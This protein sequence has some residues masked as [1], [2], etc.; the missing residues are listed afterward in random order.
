MTVETPRTRRRTRPPT[1]SVFVVDDHPAVR[2]R[3][4]ALLSD[5]P[6][7]RAAGSA[8]NA[9][10][11]L[12]DVARLTPRV[13]VIDSQ[14]GGES[15]LWLADQVTQLPVPPRTLIYSAF[16]DRRLAMAALVAGAHGIV[17][18]TNLDGESCN[19]I[20]VIARGRLALPLLSRTEIDLLASRLGEEDRPVPRMLAHGLRPEE[21]ARALRLDSGR[22]RAARTRIVSELTRAVSPTSAGRL[23][24]L[25]WNRASR[26]HWTRPGEP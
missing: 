11:A 10:A 5:K 7:L 15:G 24:Q 16:A 23:A 20:R 8:T 26:R 2:R 22:M 13:V 9:T 3:I 25:N 1:I 4:E 17:E 21:T 14:L 19:A 6:D 12:A 18:K